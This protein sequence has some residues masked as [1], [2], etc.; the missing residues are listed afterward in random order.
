ME[1]VADTSGVEGGTGVQL[2]GGSGEPKGA[3][4]GGVDCV[5]GWGGEGGCVEGCFEEGV[6]GVWDCEGCGWFCHVEE[7][8]M[9][10]NLV[11][12]LLS[13]MIIQNIYSKH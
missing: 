5:A 12:S 4:E 7:A 11:R 3:T 10:E 1:G 8:F 2:V 13:F 9:Q 6:V